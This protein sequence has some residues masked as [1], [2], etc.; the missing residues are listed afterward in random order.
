MFGG[1]KVNE[2]TRTDVIQTD[3][4]DLYRGLYDAP[5]AAALSGVPET[6]LH[7]W[8]RKGIYVPSISPEPRI[9]YWSWMDLLALRMIHWLRH[10]DGDTKAVPMSKVR[11]ALDVLRDLN[12]PRQL[13]HRVVVG[14]LGN[15]VY[16]KVGDSVFRADTSRQGLMLTTVNLIEP[17]GS[18]PDLLEPRPQ[19]RIIPGKLH[20]EPHILGTRIAT[21]TIYALH[22]DGY[23]SG[24]IREMY[25]EANPHAL[26]QAIDLEL[27][28][29]P[30][31]A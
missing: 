26:E 20:G 30:H 21:A 24:D 16:V 9:R 4:V 8:A 17:Y 15:D 14:R 22:E 7:Y 3:N 19:I 25:P 6:T 2:D 29:L 1:D 12:I 11:D 31:A 18:G 5:R 28:L 27:S 10:D 13:F 23:S